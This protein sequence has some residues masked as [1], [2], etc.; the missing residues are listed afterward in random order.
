MPAHDVLA[1][2]V[3][4]VVA[5]DALVA[6]CGVTGEG[7]PGAGV[8]AEVAEHHGAHVDRGAQ[9]GRDPLLAAVEHRPLGVPR[10]EHRADRQLQLLARVL[11]EGHLAVLGDDRL[12]GVDQHLQVARLQAHVVG[13][14]ALALQLLQRVVEEVRRD[15]QHRLAEHRQQPAV[16]VPGE[17]LVVGLTRQPL[18][19]LVVEAHVED[20]VHHPG[21]RELRPRAH[22]DQQRVVGV[23]QRLAHRLLERGEVLG[24]LLARGRRA[25]PRPP[26]PPRAPARGRHGRPRW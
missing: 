3:A 20:R 14:V 16:G 7:D 13:D 6:R 12:V 5:V 19:R 1:L 24:D 10:V 18:H 11:R 25:S 8:H 9:V 15:V 26:A 4:Q 17:A 23:T 21:H 22:R 2:R